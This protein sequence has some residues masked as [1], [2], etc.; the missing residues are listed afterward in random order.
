MK[1]RILIISV[2]LILLGASACQAQTASPSPQVQVT[3]AASAYPM[4][5]QLPQTTLPEVY[6]APSNEAYPA[7]LNPE[8][9]GGSS[10]VAF[11]LDR[12]ISPEATQVTGVGTPGVPLVLVDVTNMGEFI[13]ETT[14]QTDGTFRFEVKSLLANNRIGLMMG[15]LTQT[16]W[17]VESFYAEGYYGPEAMSLP[18]I[19][20]VY[21][22]CVVR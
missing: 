5:T 4:A 21:D 19:G 11:K 14:V 22:S 12:P 16:S 20:T 13:A 2:M 15:D 18:S 6:P 7:P 1:N 9:N 8:Q 10:I 3:E 17:T